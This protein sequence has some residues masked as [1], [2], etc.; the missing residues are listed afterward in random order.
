MASQETSENTPAMH[1]PKWVPVQKG[2]WVGFFLLAVSVIVGPVSVFLFSMNLIGIGIGAKLNLLLVVLPPLG[3]LLSP[4]LIFVGWLLAAGR[5]KLILFLRRF[6]SEQLNDAVR[7]LVQTRLRRRFRLVTLDDSAFS[8]A[9]ALWSGLLVSLLPAGVTLILIFS[10]Y[11]GF[12]KVAQSELEDETP[13]GAALALLQV[14]MLGLGLLAFVVCLVL[15]VMAIRAHFAAKRKIDSQKSRS[16]VV[17]KLRWHK[18]LVRAP[19]IAAPMATVVTTTDAEWQ[20]TVLTIAPL[21]EV[22]LLDLSSPSDSILWE[23]ETVL[24]LELHVIL[25]ARRDKFNQ[26]WDAE[27]RGDDMHLWSKSRALAEGLPLIVYEAPDRI[28]ETML[29]DML[30]K[31]PT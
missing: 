11:G 15:T 26:W 21:C 22:V 3:I 19:S 16:K 18:S 17:R 13:F 10:S 25:L 9:G 30:L 2:R 29:E 5:K 6:G 28:G 24:S 12:A 1:G 31:L 14:G 4:L 8:P 7:A 23:L 20:P 27:N